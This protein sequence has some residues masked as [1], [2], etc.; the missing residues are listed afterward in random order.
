[1]DAFKPLNGWV[2]PKQIEYWGR[3]K[4]KAAELKVELKKA[5]KGPVDEK[6]IAKINSDWMGLYPWARKQLIKK[7]R[8]N[9]AGDTKVIDKIIVKRTHKPVCLF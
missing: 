9:W 8:K 3:N 4:E 6:L 7:L 5:W 2:T 1:M